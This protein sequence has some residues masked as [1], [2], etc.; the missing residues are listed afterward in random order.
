MNTLYIIFIIMTIYILMYGIISLFA[1]VIPSVLVFRQIHKNN[2]RYKELI[3]DKKSKKISLI[4]NAEPNI[5]KFMVK[6][7]NLLY[8]DYDNYDIYIVNTSGDLKFSR[9]II[10]YFDLKKNSESIKYKTNKSEIISIYKNDKINLLNTEKT[11]K[12]NGINAAA[13]NT[14]ADLILAIEENIFIEKNA[15]KKL[16]REFLINDNTLFTSGIIKD[17]SY[18][19]RENL[20]YKG[21]KTHNFFSCFSILRNIKNKLFEKTY[22]FE[23]L[24]GEEIGNSFTLYNLGKIRKV[25]GFNCE[26]SNPNNDLKQ[27]LTGAYKNDFKINYDALAF[28]EIDDIHEYVTDDIIDRYIIKKDVNN[29]NPYNTISRLYD[30]FTGIINPILEFPIII[31][32]VL[33]TIIKVISPLTLLCFMLLYI[34]FDIAK[35]ILLHITDKVSLRKN[36]NISESLEFIGFTLIYNFGFR[37]LYNL[38]KL[39]LRF[40]LKA[41]REAYYKEKEIYGY[42]NEFELIEDKRYEKELTEY[43]EKTK[44]NDTAIEE[45]KETNKISDTKL[46]EKGFILE[47]EN[48]EEITQIIEEINDIKAEE[49]AVET[50]EKAEN[51][52]E[53]INET[54]IEEHSENEETLIKELENFDIEEV[55]KSEPFKKEEVF[56]EKKPESELDRIMRE[57]A[58]TTSKIEKLEAEVKKELSNIE[59][60]ARDKDIDEE[61]NKLKAEVLKVEEN[62]DTIKD[63]EHHEAEALKEIASV[64]DKEDDELNFSDDEMDEEFSNITI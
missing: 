7:K 45:I 31:L 10:E 9:K 23:Y 21:I 4:L 32:S 38:N 35:N 14:N 51:Q 40:G 5:N 36:I 12:W 17:D 52:K 55:A 58:K 30:L 49:I 2:K 19:H 6:V 46:S 20:E 33:F 28:E 24:S 64:K 44:I 57:L 63:N 27:R 1:G 61:L 16:T 22:N 50:E 39:L 43:P 29:S 48:E 11:N 54:V 34:S 41:R 8:L 15:L 37:Q 47:D 13:D 56:K 60:R 59:R 42:I 53:I 25:G 62:I 3:E 18:I 26:T